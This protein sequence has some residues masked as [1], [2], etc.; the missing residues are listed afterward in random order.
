MT[1]DTR[2]L[3]V[4]LNPTGL[5]ESELVKDISGFADNRT[6]SDYLVFL[7]GY[8]AGAL[9][10]EECECKRPINAEGCKPDS[11]ILLPSAPCARATPCR[12]LDKAEG[13]TPDNNN[14]HTAALSVL[15]ERLRQIDGEGYTAEG[16]D[17]YTLGQL[18]DAAGAYAWHAHTCNMDHHK[19]TTVP[20][21]WPWMAEHWKPT[22]QRQML[23]KA[24]AL[25]L[26]EI[27]RLDR[28]D[29]RE[30]LA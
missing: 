18:A 23:V 8:K 26:A 11:N 1:T 22:N 3:F 15:E 13:G 27:E 17:H 25:I 9:D 28:K 20:P 5:S 14:A 12:N 19:I 2:D 29:A 30:V 10:G 6:H 24:G 7:A 21:S 16:D 4:K